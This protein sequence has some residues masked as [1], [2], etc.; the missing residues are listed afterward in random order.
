MVV[1][2]QRQDA[3]LE[4]V[5][6]PGPMTKAYRLVGNHTAGATGAADLGRQGTGLRVVG[7]DG[8]AHLKGAPRRTAV[9]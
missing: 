1:F 8:K 3:E 5:H 9:V 4:A 7:G 6:R 2:L